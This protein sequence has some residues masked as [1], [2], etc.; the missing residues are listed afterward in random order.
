[1]TCSKISML[2]FVIVLSLFPPRFSAHHS[3]AGTFAAEKM[4]VL[5]GVVVRTEL[6]NPH[7][8]IYVDVRGGNGQLQRWALEGPQVSQS[9]RMGFNRT[10]L[11]LGDRL[12]VCGYLTKDDSAMK[13]DNNG[14]S[15][16]LLASEVL[17]LPTGQKIVWG[18]GPRRCLPPNHPVR[19]FVDK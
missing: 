2:A 3:F 14:K 19:I 5:S 13:P 12:E 8:F 4:I 11:K 10:S 17:T 9:E 7:V 1:M 15:V 6:V 18:Y 16:R